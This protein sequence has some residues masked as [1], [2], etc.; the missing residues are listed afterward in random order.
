MRQYERG[1]V[2][3]NV[4]INDLERLERISAISRATEAADQREDI[5]YDDHRFI[6]I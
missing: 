6:P 3:G 1:T 5:T 4:P 2:R